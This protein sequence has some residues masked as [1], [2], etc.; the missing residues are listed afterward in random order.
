MISYDQLPYPGSA[1]EHTHPAVLAAIASLAG[2]SP[3]PLA[4]CRVLELGCAAGRNLLPLA[5]TFPDAQF[6]GVDLAAGHIAE[7]QRI[8][9]ELGI[10]NARLQQADILA[11]DESLGRFDFIIAHGVFSWV[12][13]PVQQRILHLCRACLAPQG[14]AVISYNVYPGWHAID[15]LRHG[16]RYRARGETEPARQVAAARAHVEL[17][18]R[19]RPEELQPPVGFASA[20]GQLIAAYASYCEQKDEAVLI[21][22]ELSPVNRPFYLWEFVEL[23]Q[24][25][26]LQFLGDG[27]LATTSPSALPPR[28]RQWVMAQAGDRIEREQLMDFVR[29]RSFR[30]T[31]LCHREHRL[32]EQPAWDDLCGLHFSSR[33]AVSVDD[34]AEGRSARMATVRSSDGAFFETAHRLTLAAFR[35]LSQIWPQACT[36][37]ELA[38]ALADSVTASGPQP[39]GLDP[40]AASDIFGPA[41]PPDT[42]DVLRLAANLLH[43]AHLSAGLAELRQDPPPIA[44]PPDERPVASAWAR[45][46]AQHSLR[47]TNLLHRPVELDEISR[48]LLLRL[49]GCTDVPALAAALRRAQF[50]PGS[51]ALP[52]GL[53]DEQLQGIVRGQ[54]RWLASAGLLQST[55][56]ASPD[57]PQ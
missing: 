35:H 40:L 18:R 28:M 37:P 43:A 53:Q 52:P 19:V 45:W 7:G 2:L 31:L 22:D 41:P 25:H 57:F 44:L 24:A 14:V 12:P 11:L 38:N 9:A 42:P 46:E 20:Y 10:G 3:A 15:A 50:P 55:S 16:M 36:P 8:C 30:Y 29:N 39:P 47:V 13:G 5:L 34:S 21:H 51:E 4:T 56:F 23:A 26:E 49:D 6:V 48:F 17:L 27:E 54:V 32:R 33:A 1:Y